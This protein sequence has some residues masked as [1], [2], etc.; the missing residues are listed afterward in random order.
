MKPLETDLF[1]DIEILSLFVMLFAVP[2]LV[3]NIGSFFLQFLFYLLV[4]F[5]VPRCFPVFLTLL[6]F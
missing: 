3:L 5:S 1:P 4:C 6:M 2:V